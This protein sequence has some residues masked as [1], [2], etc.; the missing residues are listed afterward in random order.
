M[1][2][3][4]MLLATLLWSSSVVGSKV[5]VATLAVTEVAAGRFLFAAGTL[6]L[7][8]LA[9]RR[10]AGLNQVG[11]RPL[12]MG[13]LD[14]GLV[15]LLMIWGLSHTVAVNVAVFWS[16]MPLLLPILARVCLHDRLQP[17]IML[18]AC[19]A[20]GGAMLLVWNQSDLGQG[21]LFGDMLAMAGVLCACVNALVARRVAQSQAEPM[22]VTAYQ[23]SMAI[24]IAAL[25]FIVIERP[26][27]PLQGFDL[28][29]SL[30]ILCL[31][32]VATAGPFLLYNFALRHLTVGRISLFPALVGPLAIPMAAVFLGETVTTTDLAAVLL[33]MAGV[34][35]P[36]LWEHPVVVRL[37][38]RRSGPPLP[39]RPVY[40]PGELPPE[41][42]LRDLADRPLRSLRFVVFDTETTGLRPSH[43]DEIVQIAGLRVDGQG[44]HVDDTFE[45]LVNPGK[46]IPPASIKFHGITDD[47]VADVPGTS[48]VLPKFHAFC[49]GDIL[50]AHN[51]AFDMKFL[52]LQEDTSGVRFDQ[53]VLCTLLLSAVLCRKEHDH[54][55]DSIAE[56]FGIDVTDRHTAL[57]DARVTAAVFLKL[58]A[59]AEERGVH[60][61]GDALRISRKARRFR[62]M[63]K[64]F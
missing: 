14:P 38:P 15:S 23:M 33:V 54:R 34:A 20:F 8:V 3:L 45:S 28:D 43:G 37:I 24:V 61:L 1:P 16:L 4:A 5:A 11:K 6:W 31:G 39:E 64:Q 51:A 25:A 36:S 18:G 32:T 46:P 9:T 40:H 49:D 62:R 27:E 26:A 58:L 60:T 42:D 13:L 29:T 63:Q 7:L 19:L 48:D 41:P 50:V 10:Y 53:P 22:V 55:L 21:S 52:S 44:V 2:V 35:L 17:S 30:L 59:L 57:G 47:M 56:R 12:L